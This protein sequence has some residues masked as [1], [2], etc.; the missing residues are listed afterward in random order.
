MKKLILFIYGFMAFVTFGHNNSKMSGVFRHYLQ[1]TLVPFSF[2]RLVGNSISGM[3]YK[4]D[5][6]VCF[7]DLKSADEPCTIFFCLYTFIY[8]YS[9]NLIMKFR[10]FFNEPI[11]L[12]IDNRAI[13][14]M[15]YL[16]WKGGL[17]PIKNRSQY[18]SISIMMPFPY[19]G[20]IQK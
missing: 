10:I 17:I 18:L 5:Y 20:I 16:K 8:I 12:K 9:I 14:R 4:P 11:A 15:I 19:I 7:W 6:P 3:S 1:F 2:G 13:S